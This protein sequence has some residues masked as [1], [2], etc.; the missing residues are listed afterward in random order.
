MAEVSQAADGGSALVRCELCSASVRVDE[1]RFANGHRVCA[2][3]AGQLESELARASVPADVLPRAVAMG[4]LGAL[5]GAG[6]WALVLIVTKF[7]IGY[8]AVLVGFLA[9]L[10]VKYGARGATG[11]QLQKVAVA[12]TFVGLVATKYLVFAHFFSVAAAK[13]GVALGYFSPGVLL[14]FPRAVFSMLTP[15]D[16]LWVLIAFSSAWRVPAPPRVTV[17]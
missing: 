12:C 1:S 14:T 3:C 17:T 13:E 5:V 2:T 7:E 15:F 4:A 11:R 16:L 9:G 10:G 6:I 8:L